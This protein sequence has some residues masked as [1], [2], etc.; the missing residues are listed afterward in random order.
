MPSINSFR[1]KD[2]SN[3]RNEI[4]ENVKG[5]IILLECTTTSGKLVRGKNVPE[6]KNHWG[7]I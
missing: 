4:I 3:P 7:I 6:K 2:F 5:N 1:S